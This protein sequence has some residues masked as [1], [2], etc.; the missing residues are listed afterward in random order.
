MREHDAERAEVRRRKALTSAY[1]MALTFVQGMVVG[2]S[3]RLW[4]S[5]P[6]AG[7]LLTVFGGGLT[8]AEIFLFLWDNGVLHLG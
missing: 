3:I 5:D 8:V 6:A 2:W 4:T 7:V 1:V